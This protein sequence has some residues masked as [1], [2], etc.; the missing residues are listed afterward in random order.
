MIKVYYITIF[1]LLVLTQISCDKDDDPINYDYHAHVISPSSADKSLGETLFISVDFESH[2]GEAVKHINVRIFNADNTLVVYDQP[3]N[4][5][6]AGDASSYNF[7]DQFVL[8]A[9]NGVTAGAWVLEAK[10]WGAEDGSDEVVER[11]EFHVNP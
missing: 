4:P 9:A 10:V 7:S 3:S 1:S 8:S 2:S 11:I 5:H 6:I